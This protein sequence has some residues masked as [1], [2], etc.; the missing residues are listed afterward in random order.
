MFKELKPGKR[1]SRKKLKEP[2]EFITL[3]AK[4]IRFLGKHKNKFI[5]G[6]VV[7]LLIVAGFS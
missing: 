2:D 5:P 4:G 3:S 6:V 1:I 7:A